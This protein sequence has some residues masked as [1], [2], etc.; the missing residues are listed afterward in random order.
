MKKKVIIFQGTKSPT[1]SGMYKTKFWYLKFDKRLSY[2]KDLITGWKGNISPKSKTK[3]K[4]SS[5]ASAIGY[6]EKKNY[7]YE[8]LKRKESEIKIKSYADNFRYNRHKSDID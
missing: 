3:L 4:F 7:E 6:A 1:Q 8:I 2:E 5:L